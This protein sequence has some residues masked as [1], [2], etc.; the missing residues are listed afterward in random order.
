MDFFEV[1]VVA[2]AVVVEPVE[3]ECVEYRRQ[4]VIAPEVEV[5][6]AFPRCSGPRQPPSEPLTPLLRQ[7]ALDHQVQEPPL[8]VGQLWLQRVPLLEPHQEL[9]AEFSF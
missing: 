7:Q 9:P 2:V 8:L 5:E 6:P 1:A 3:E 4:V